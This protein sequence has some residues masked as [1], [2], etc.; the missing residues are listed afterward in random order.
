[1]NSTLAIRL[2]A[3]CS[4]APLASA[5]ALAQDAGYFYGGLGI[6]TARATLDAQAIVGEQA[7]V[8]ASVIDRNDRDT[9]YKLFGGYQMTPNLG[10]EAGYF[11]LGRFGFDAIT[12]PPGTFAANSSIQGLNV[13]LVGTLP[14]GERFSLLG[15]LGA[16]HA[17][18]RTALS[19]TVG[20]ESMDAHY[21]ERKTNF[22]IGAGLQYAFSPSFLMRGEAERYRVSDAVNHKVNVDTLSLS[23]VFPFGQT[24]APA[25]RAMAPA[26]VAPAPAPAPVVVVQAPEPVVATPPP[27]P[28]PAPVVVPLRRVSFSAESLHEF[29]KSA[30]QDEGRRALDTFLKELEGTSFDM[31][32]V[33]GHTDR[34][35]TPDYN[36]RL[37]Q[38][39]ADAVKAYL[40]STG[41]VDPMKIT[42]V[43][44]GE[45]NPVTSPEACRGAA[46]TAAL[47]ACLQ[48]DR[49]VEIEVS[50]TR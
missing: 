26:Y 42:A 32:T 17:R 14:M 22:K 1:M 27:A 47:I 20:E 21:S 38:E 46:A 11:R 5:A 34:L 7:G 35:G 37:S 43:G 44:K 15:R 9:T 10:I 30:L 24:A 28:P 48:P 6:G 13:D 8:S 12:A 40:V 2:L 19:A 49:R 45:S 41:K 25:P 36:Q 31:V 50:G 39:R 33:E 4:L 3:A 16:Q 23:L 29:D 18:T